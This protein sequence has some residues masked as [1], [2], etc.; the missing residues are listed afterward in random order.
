MFLKTKDQAFEAFKRYKA[1][2]ENH[3]DAKIQCLQNDKG[4]E[5]MSTF[6][7]LNYLL[8]NGIT[9]QHTVH[10]HPQQNSVAEQA[11]R[12]IEEHVVAMLTNLAFHHHF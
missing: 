6:E 3:L 7:F 4:G 9:H 8:D 11:N 1:Y 2:A 12:T 10:A 5:Y